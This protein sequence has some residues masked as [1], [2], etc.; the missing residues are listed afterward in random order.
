MQNDA[1]YKRLYAH[2]EL[3]ADLLRSCV[4]E[5]WIR[6]LDFTTLERVPGSHVDQKLQQR[7]SDVIWRL[8]LSHSERWVYVYLLLEF[9][10]KSD[11][12]MPIRMLNYVGLFYDHLL[13]T[14]ALKAGEP[15]PLVLPIVLYNGEHRWRQ[16][17]SLKALR[18]ELPPELERHQPE[19]VSVLIDQGRFL[20]ELPQPEAETLSTLLFRM[21]QAET[22]DALAEATRAMA[23]LLQQP[24]YQHLATSIGIWL[25]RV[26]LPPMT[27]DLEWTEINDFW[28]LTD[29]LQ[30]R[31]R[32]WPERWKREGR[33]EGLAEGRLEGRLL[34]RQEGQQEGEIAGQRR[35]ILR[36]T[37]KRFGADVAALVGTRLAAIID[38]QRLEE[39]AEAFLDCSSSEQWLERIGAALN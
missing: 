36:L 19:L 1:S 11:R 35:A 7:H 3:V 26:L 6:Q 5:A 30:E 21:D 12:W 27:T 37:Q 14:R 16:P 34:G 31:V 28:E 4:R 8:R 24:A 20:A 22:E 15:L 9:Q 13:Q 25:K 39:L 33:A 10:S 29:M 32:R 23:A 38:A 18:G 17:L 2:A